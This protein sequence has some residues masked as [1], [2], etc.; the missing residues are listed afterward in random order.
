MRFPTI[1]SMTPF[2][3]WLL[4]LALAV[5]FILLPFAGVLLPIG[6]TFASAFYFV[7]VGIALLA[8]YAVLVRPRLFAASGVLLGAAPW[9]AWGIVDG[10]QRCARFN[11]SPSGGCEADPSAQVTLAVIVY[12]AAVV[13]TGAAVRS[14]R[15]D[16]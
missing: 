4:G 9:L 8:A 14:S 1:T 2:R 7:P 6:S 5:L 10:L 16:P 3:A 15:R 13:V 11:R 12:V